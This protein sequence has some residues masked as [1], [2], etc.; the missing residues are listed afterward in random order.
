MSFAVE[1]VGIYYLYHLLFFLIG[2]ALLRERRVFKNPCTHR[3]AIVIPAHDEENVIHDSVRSV[4]RCNYP[5]NLYD[6]YV[7]ADNCTDQTAGLARSAGARVLERYHKTLRG[8]Q[9]ALKWAFERIDLDDYDAV[10]ILDADNHV[11]PD[12]LRVLDRELSAGH[13]VIQAYVETKNPCDSWVTANYAYMFWYICRLQM[14]RTR[15]G[16]SAWLAGTGVCISTEILRRVGWNV[17][18]LTDDVEY[19]CQLILAGERVVFAPDAVVYDQKP[20][21]LKDSLRQRLRW[22]RGQTQVSFRY[23]P[24]LL[25]FAVWSWLQ[26]NLTQAARAVD[27]VMWVPMHLVV[28]ASVVFSCW[29]DASSYL[30][31]VFVTVPVFNLMPMLAERIRHCRAWAY[32]VTAGLFFVTWWPITAYGVISCGNKAWWRTPH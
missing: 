18:T 19:T 8:K 2:L 4:L 11:D 6:V 13:K 3:F 24:R 7:I 20:V 32:L 22:I 25:I 17:E 26:G 16:L 12:L 1:L 30:L 31:A 10:V 28:F 23:I 27:A 21:H 14:V 15:L 29:S 9:H 5:R